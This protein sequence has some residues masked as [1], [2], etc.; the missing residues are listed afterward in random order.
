VDARYSSEAAARP[1]RAWFSLSI[2][3]PAP[4]LPPRT[5]V[6]GVDH[7]HQSPESGVGPP[8]S[9][10]SGSA[11]PVREPQRPARRTPIPDDVGPGPSLSPVIGA[12]ADC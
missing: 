6:L 1:D 12:L 5:D 9:S 4:V 8:K 2:H 10:A 7:R 3:K 11:V